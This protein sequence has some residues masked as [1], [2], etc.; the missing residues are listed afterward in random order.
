MKIDPKDQ[1]PLKP[2]EENQKVSKK[3]FSVDR[4]PAGPVEG[5]S[6]TE[7]AQQAHFPGVTSQF[8]KND[9]R[10]PQKVNTIMRR[11]VEELLQTEFS[12]ARFP[13]KE[14]RAKFVEFMSNDEQFQK[15]MTKHLD[16]L[17]PER[18]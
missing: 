7:K 4:A 9:L 1:R 2:A 10:D 11:S 3:P 14:A 6:L 12:Q 17:L 18:S 5:R 8:S 16:K 13:S 15:M